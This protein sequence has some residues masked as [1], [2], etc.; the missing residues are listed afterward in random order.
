MLELYRALQNTGMQW[1][2]IDAYHIKA[3]YITPKSVEIL[4]ELQLF[5]VEANSYLVDFRNMTPP[6]EQH[7]KG[8]EE[9]ELVYLSTMGFH[10]V[11]FLL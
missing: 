3:R 2:T 8:S 1:I 10:D 5:T 11:H 6:F 4:I 7:F 9:S